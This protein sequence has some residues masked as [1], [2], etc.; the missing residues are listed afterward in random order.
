M[1]CLLMVWTCDPTGKL[2]AVEGSNLFP[3]W[4]PPAGPFF[5]GLSGSY[6]PGSGMGGAATYPPAAGAPFT[7]QQQQ[8]QQPESP[9]GVGAGGTS[10]AVLASQLASVQAEVAALQAEN[11]RLRC[12]GRREVWVGG[13]VGA[14]GG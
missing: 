5:S 7:W 9:W 10:A 14:A 1:C 12:G 8:Q 6:T 3:V 4:P 13:W 2:K 11:A